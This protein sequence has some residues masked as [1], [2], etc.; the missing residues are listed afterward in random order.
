MREGASA[1]ERTVL[2]VE[3][4][5]AFTRVL[6]R[7]LSGPWRFESVTSVADALRAIEQT[8]KL[9][10]V[11]IDLMLPDGSG[12]EVVSAVRARWALVPVIVLTGHVL[13]PIIN[14]I[15]ALRAEYLLKL[16]C[17][18]AM[19]LLKER[20]VRLSEAGGESAR[21]VVEEYAQRHH[22]TT[23]ETDVLALAVAD[24]PRNV[25]TTRLG[26]SPDTLKTHVKSILQ[27]CDEKRFDEL[28]R[29]LRVAS[30]TPTPTA[31]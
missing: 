27:K 6:S 3:D 29:K 2:V 30:R 8:G 10:A 22:L 24:V 15:W 1:A 20:L 17:V 5:A 14:Q 31:T 18:P 9:H 19:K 21:Q 4:D 26:I 28:A 11:I 13:G 25:I 7:Y 23:R 16:D 12:L